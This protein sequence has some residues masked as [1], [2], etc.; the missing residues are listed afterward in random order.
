VRRGLLAVLL[1]LALPAAAA[2]AVRIQSVDAGGYPAVRLTVVTD[3][4][5]RVPPLVRENGAPAAGQQ[6]E[7]L[8]RA[9]SVVLGVDRS[10]SM[11]GRPL[12]EAVAAAR[13][14]LAGKPAAD[15]IAVATFATQALML[16]GFSSSTIDADTA[17]RSISVDPVQGTKLYDGLVLAARSLAREELPSRVIIVV[18]DGNETRSRSSL[19]DVIAAARKAH[20]SI[21]VVGIESSRFTPAPLRRLAAS[22]GGRYYGAASLGALRSVYGSIARE[23]R[24][25][26]RVEYLSA[27]VPGERARLSVSVPGQGSAKA[28]FTPSAAPRPSGGGSGLP[29]ALY[30]PW[31]LALLAFAVGALVFLAYGLAFSTGGAERLR[32]QLAAHVQRRPAARKGIKERRGP[33]ESL[34]GLLQATER[35]FGHTRLWLKLGRLLERADVPLKT[36]ELVY[37]MLASGLALGIL[38]ALTGAPP[39]AILLFLLLGLLLPLGVVSWKAKRRLS[40]F[41]SQLP[42]LL[43][44]IAASLK[45]GHSFKQGLQAVVDEGHE[46]AGK[47]FTRV[48]NE[49]RLGRPLE[50]ALQDMVERLG[51]KNLAFIVTA[52]SVQSQVGG[53]LAGLFDMVAETVRNR[54]QFARKIKALTAMGRMSAYVLVGLPFLVGGAIA[55]MNPQYMAPLFHTSAGHKLLLLG[56]AMMAFGSF[57]LKR[58]V[59]F[60]G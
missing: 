42:D 19:A 41:E 31:G 13:A 52:V 23:L 34:A 21:Y 2:A 59:S 15:R 47:E 32:A 53:S 39:A 4:P 30:A 56:L 18:T 35:A 40:A 54:Q 28:A 12:R 38:L 55:L 16:T 11:A 51:S 50:D 26:W 48:L 36:A 49:A 9:K 46:P 44:S 5:S 25:T 10:Q 20:V 43:L 6:A 45:A 7:N 33:R 57:L 22:T 14:F 8:G 24:R 58:I 1:A 3:R 37:L 29:P 60:K 27:A 17:L